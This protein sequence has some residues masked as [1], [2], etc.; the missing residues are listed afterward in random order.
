MRFQ[1][2]YILGVLVTVEAL[3]LN[4]VEKRSSNAGEYAMDLSDT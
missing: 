1:I 3:A 4:T 2:A